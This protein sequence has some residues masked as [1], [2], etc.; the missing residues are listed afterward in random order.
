MKIGGNQSDSDC[1]VQALRRC[2][3]VFEVELKKNSAMAVLVQHL[4]SVSRACAA[5]CIL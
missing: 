4:V 5:P 1:M 2:I 3:L